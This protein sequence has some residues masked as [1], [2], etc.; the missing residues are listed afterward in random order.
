MWPVAHV[1]RATLIAGIMYLGSVLLSGWTQHMHSLSD[2]TVSECICCMYWRS[3]GSPVHMTPPASL[4]ES[5]TWQLESTQRLTIKCCMNAACSKT[6]LVPFRVE[7]PY[8]RLGLLSITVIY[9][10]NYGCSFILH[11]QLQSPK[12]ELPFS[13]HAP[14]QH[15]SHQSCAV[16]DSFHRSKCNFS[17][18]FH[19]ENLPNWTFFVTEAPAIHPN[20]EPPFKSLLRFLSPPPPFFCH[21]KN[22]QSSFSFLTMSQS[23]LLCIIVLCSAPVWKHLFVLLQH[24]FIQF[25]FHLYLFI[26]IF[27]HRYLCQFKCLY[28][29][30]L[31]G[32]AQTQTSTINS[33]LHAI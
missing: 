30:G 33:T 18:F 4:Q 25:F 7:K 13:Y 14:L 16:D 5:Y 2:C 11:R 31:C 6:C 24:S 1:N 28:C 20:N 22:Q 23:M 27:A 12:E 21:H 26:C 10:C 19:S 32:L 29:N 15:H 8:R 3:T 9:L 17:H